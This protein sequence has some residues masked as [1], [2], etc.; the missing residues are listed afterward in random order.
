M[1]KE[2]VLVIAVPGLSPK[3][4]QMKVG[5]VLVTV[6]ELSTAKLLAFPKRVAGVIGTALRLSA[7]N[8]YRNTT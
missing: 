8:E 3:S 2:P 1:T 6:E 5:P 7:D 4:P